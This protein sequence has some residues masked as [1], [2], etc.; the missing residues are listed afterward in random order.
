MTSQECLVA[1]MEAKCEL[2]PEGCRQLIFTDEDRDDLLRWNDCDASYALSRIEEY[3]YPDSKPTDSHL[4]P[5]CV[6]H[7][8]MC[9]SCEFASRHGKCGLALNN[10]YAAALVLCAKAC[11]DKHPE[12][13]SF[14]D[15]IEPHIDRLR[16]ILQRGV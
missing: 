11:G 14:V 2:L 6:L 7:Y 9:V 3:C 10:D 15:F 8:T 4:C 13:P 1:Y 12:G 5:W 16:E